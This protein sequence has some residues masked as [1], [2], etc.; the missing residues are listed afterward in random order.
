MNQLLV[1]M[2]SVCYVCDIYLCML[3]APFLVLVSS[4]VRSYYYV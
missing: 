1:M 3:V 4:V 2:M